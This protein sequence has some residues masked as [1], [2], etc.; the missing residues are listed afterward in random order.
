MFYCTFNFR[1]LSTN[2]IAALPTNAI[3][4]LTLQKLY[5]I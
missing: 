3:P 4:I 5:D 1:D 2:V